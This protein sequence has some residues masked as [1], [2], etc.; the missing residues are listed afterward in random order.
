MLQ[1]LSNHPIAAVLAGAVLISFS[2]VWVKLSEL[3][4]TTSAFYRVFFGAVFLLL[5]SLRSND[6]PK[7]SK[8]RFNL[9]ALC[10][11][12]FAL[13]LIFWHGAIVF[14]GPGLATMLGNFQVFLM[15]GVA[16]FFFKEP[17]R[18]RLMISLPLS[19]GG[20][21][22]I[23]GPDWN[24]L[25]DQ[26]K[27]GILLGL[28]T[29][30]CYTGFLLSLRKIQAETSM[31]F[32]NS[33]LLLSAFCA[34]FLGLYMLATGKS[35]SFPTLQSLVTMLIL[36]LFSQTIGWLMITNA[37]PKINPALTGLV[38]LLQ[39][40]LSFIWDVLFFNRPT[41]LIN[42]FGVIITIGAIYLGIAKN[43]P[44]SKND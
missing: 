16:V 3:P 18:L 7:L 11:F 2:A 25:G 22:L 5:A 27:L 44:S 29:A 34:F 1:K 23:V 39:P 21:Y 10:A 35:F 31:S 42:W 38:L 41:T 30:V 15:A 13:D 19:A 4:P 26:Y 33:L 17:L 6:F 36:G 28:A 14:I 24:Q 12:L 37:M 43:T 40:S 20:L 9:L 8:K 32:Y